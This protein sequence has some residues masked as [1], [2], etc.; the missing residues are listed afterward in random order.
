MILL[1]KKGN[2]VLPDLTYLNN[3]TWTY[4]CVVTPK[5]GDYYSK[6]YEKLFDLNATAWATFNHYDFLKYEITV[7]MQETKRVNGFAIDKLPL[8]LHFSKKTAFMARKTTV[9]FS[10]DGSVWTEAIDYTLGT[11]LGEIDLLSIA[12]PTNARYLK[13]VLTDQNYR[14]VYSISLQKIRIF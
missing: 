2:P 1:K 10:V 13:F 14:N 7:D 9:Q 5:E 4:E 3:E 12:A 6:G 11:T 8:I